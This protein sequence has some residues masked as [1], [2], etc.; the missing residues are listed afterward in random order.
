M[1][2]P[3]Y[4]N[5]LEPWEDGIYTSGPAV[6]HTI[7]RYCRHTE[8]D[9]FGDLLVLEPWQRWLLNEAFRL[10]DATDQRQWRQVL[11]RVPRGNAK[12]TIST[13]VGFH[14]L[15]FDG[16]GRPEQYSAAW[17]TQQASRQIEQAKIMRDASPPLKDRTEAYA[18][19]IYCPENY[20]SWRAV[21]KLADLQQGTK[22]SFVILDELHVHA[23]ND[24]FDAF[25]RGMQKRRQ[26]M[27]WVITTEGANPDSFLAQMTR[28]YLELPD[29]VEVSPYL[30]VAR[31]WDA[32]ALMIDWG[33][34]QDS[35]ADIEDPAVVR[36]CNPAGWLDPEEL[37]REQ[38]LAPGA[39]EADF[40]RFHLNQLVITD[41]EGIKPA[42]WD[43]CR[44]E[45]AVVPAGDE[46]C[47]AVDLGFR[48]DSAAV[49]W[50]GRDGD[51]VVVGARIF[52]A[53]GRRSG[54]E[55]DI[56]ET[57]EAAVEDLFG[58]FRVRSL[59]VDP[60]AAGVMMQDWQ[61]RRWPVEEFPFGIASRMAPASG[62]LHQ[63]VQDGQ[64]AHDG[65]EKLRQHVL[66][67]RM[68]D[69]RGG[70]AWVFDKRSDNKDN[71]DAKSDGGMALV[72]AVD[73][74]LADD[75][76]GLWATRGLLVL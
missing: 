45:D 21:S 63:A 32:R 12:T 10:D 25:R 57:V 19:A 30:R 27:L 8:G 59:R 46:V 70:T 71:P 73:A 56:R 18:A 15:L 72:A 64:L 53:P 42:D 75:E 40:R 58:Q 34:P 67:M 11:I 6:A 54:L 74:L 1:S 24:L 41:G 2:S 66:N 13:G 17:G 16:E 28:G 47:I 65:D 38:L 60:W 49:A 33:L 52:D 68:R 3:D 23:R 43:A 7:E 39:R 55:I 20:G 69:V 35:D 50:A 37:I 36:G 31:D 4:G 48:D 76:R 5:V 61:K 26:P 9:T 14:M 29:V 44:V 62:K 51:R 22:P